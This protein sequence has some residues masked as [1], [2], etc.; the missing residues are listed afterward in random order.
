MMMKMRRRD[1]DDEDKQDQEEDNQQEAA[2]D[3]GANDDY[4][5]YDANDDDGGNNDDG[6]NDDGSS[7]DCYT[8]AD[9]CSDIANWCD[10]ENDDGAYLDIADYLDYTECV[11]VDGQGNYE[12]TAYWARPYCDPSKEVIKMTL[13]SDPYCSQA[14]KEVNVKDF[15]G[16]Y[17]Q[18][19]MFEDFY[20]GTCIDCSESVSEV[21]FIIFRLTLRD[22]LISLFCFHELSRTI[23]LTITL[24]A[25]FATRCMTRVPNVPATWCT[26]YLTDR[27]ASA[28]GCLVHATFTFTSNDSVSL[29]LFS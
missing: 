26:I 20:S 24:E 17:F 3:G 16:I 14:M 1:R 15:S 21:L 29:Y 11:Q 25:I 4:Y 23:L 27:Y 22:F 12:G 7:N 10:G 9:E 13:F 2:Q 28:S 18:S 8:Y 19:S 5:R 6:N